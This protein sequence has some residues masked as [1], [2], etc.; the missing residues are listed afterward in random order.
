MIAITAW[1]ARDL[2]HLVV[3]N[4]AEFHLLIRLA[5][6]GCIYVMMAGLAIPGAVLLTILAGPLFGLGLGTIVASFASTTGATCAFTA[7]RRYVF[8]RGKHDWN[9]QSQLVSPEHEKLV[10]GKWELLLL[11]LTPVMPFFAVNVLAGRSRLS[12]KQFW[13]ISQIG[14]LPS[15]STDT[16]VDHSSTVGHHWNDPALPMP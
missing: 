4:A 7:S 8:C 13:L 1:F 11:R 14:M 2:L 12:I 16:Y 3:T 10:L 5:V 6:Y 9:G 15:C